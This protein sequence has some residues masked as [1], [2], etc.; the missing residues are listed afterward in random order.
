M[1]DRNRLA[2]LH[3][4]E[5]ATFAARNP[6]S[7]AAYAK[8]DHLFGRVPMTWMNKK[9]GGFPV[10]SIAPLGTASGISTATNTSTSP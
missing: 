2:E 5:M 1:I 4:I 8:A 3:K 6:K 9:A 7:K 10:T